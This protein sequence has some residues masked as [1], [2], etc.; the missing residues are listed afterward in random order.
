MPRL[1]IKKTR[2]PRPAPAEAPPASLLLDVPQ[3]RAALGGIG[4]RTLRDLTHPRG[5]LVPTR[6]GRRVFYSRRN[7]ERFIAARETAALAESP[8]AEV[9]GPSAPR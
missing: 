5:P 2:R 8:A 7:L 4:E 1:T 3:A 9:A 6:L